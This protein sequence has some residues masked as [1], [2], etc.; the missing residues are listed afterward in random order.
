ME[1]KVFFGKI[2]WSLGS[3]PL[4]L[5][6][7]FISPFHSFESW[8]WLSKII[9]IRK[10]GRKSW[11]I[12]FSA[13]NDFLVLLIFGPVTLMI[14]Q[15]RNYSQLQFLLSAFAN[16]PRSYVISIISTFAAHDKPLDKLVIDNKR[17]SGMEPSGALAVFVRSV[18][19]SYN[20]FRFFVMD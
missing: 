16:A 8:I 6:F 19:K 12:Q 1:I 13:E 17:Y 2:F 3:K 7:L 15:W 14:T 20:T 18:R 5:I 11:Y 9:I 4:I 10:Q